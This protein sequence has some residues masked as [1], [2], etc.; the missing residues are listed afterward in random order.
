MEESGSKNKSSNSNN[1]ET[2][3]ENI[4]V[5]NSIIKPLNFI[6]L[7][8]GRFIILFEDFV[9]LYSSI[10]KVGSGEKINLGPS[11]DWKNKKTVMK[12]VNDRLV[13]TCNWA[14]YIIDLKTKK[15][16]QGYVQRK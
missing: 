9:M 1:T 5:I 11:P 3:L 16:I 14:F 4:Q 2:Y 7:K 13:I 15:T 8:D 10:E 12:A 6:L